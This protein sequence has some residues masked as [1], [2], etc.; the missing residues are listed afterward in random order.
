VVIFLFGLEARFTRGPGPSCVLSAPSPEQSIKPVPIVSYRD[1][2]SL[3]FN[4][5]YSVGPGKILF[6]NLS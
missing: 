4:F 5:L 6:V 1:Q 3:L 2:A